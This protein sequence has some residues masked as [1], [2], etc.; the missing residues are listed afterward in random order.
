MTLLERIARPNPTP[1]SSNSSLLIKRRIVRLIILLVFL[2][3]LSSWTVGQPPQVRQEQH[4][5]KDLRQQPAKTLNGHFPFQVPSDVGSWHLR[6][7]QL[8]HRILV[9]TGL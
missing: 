2:T 7:E 3:H 9:A 5:S 1:S 4:L 8:R 6:A